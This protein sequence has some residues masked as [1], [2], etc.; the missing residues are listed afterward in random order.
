[1]VIEEAFSSI[2]KCAF[3]F[4]AIKPF[5]TKIYQ[6]PNLTLKVQ[7]Q[8]HGKCQ[9]Q[10]SHLRPRVQSI[11]LLFVLWQLDHFWLSE[12][13]ADSI[14]DLENSRS[15]SQPRSHLRLRVQSI[16]FF[17]CVFFVAIGPFLAEIKQI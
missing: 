14:F 1:M 11:C 9:I 3:Y 2:Y 6:I 15:R 7:S 13:I 12:I 16:C 4:V 8:G 5:L 10:W 17:V